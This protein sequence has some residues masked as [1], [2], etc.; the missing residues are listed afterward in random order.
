MDL[1][2]T[3][4]QELLRGNAADVLAREASGARARDRMEAGE[5]DADLW[6]RIAG[7]GWAGLPIAA[8][9]GGQGGSL[10]DLAVVIDQLC[11]HAAIVPFTTTALAALAVQR[12]GGEAL[13]GAL[14]PRIAGGGAS[15]S[16]ALAEG[17]GEAGGP[18]AATA[19]GGRV[20][21]EKRF[22]EY[23]RSSDYHL[24]AARRDGEP[25][26]ALV[27]REGGGVRIERDLAS[28]GRTPQAIVAYGDAPAEGWIGGAEAVDGL[29][30]LGAALAA[31]ESWSH[32]QRALDM[33]VEYVQTRV[34]FGRPIGAFQAVQMRLADLATR[35]QASNF[36]V[37]ELLWNLD[38][39]HDD[40][41]QLAV[42]KAVTA[43]T[44]ARVTQDCHLLH[45]GIGFIT[46]YD[47]YLH[48]VRG[49]EAALRYGGAGE[50]LRAV[51][52]A[53]L[54]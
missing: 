26:L 3:D 14:L 2:P 39:G 5:P 7:L 1:Q 38:R 37:H 29:R 47:L 53:L 33:T 9:H 52:G 22:V 6:A 13:R 30:R 10:L 45:G 31:L 36:L 16:I 17:R 44:V 24:V 32:A 46:E 4:L 34:Q 15:V 43:D 8:E 40:P 41:A 51:A 18:I 20:R 48:T 42:V 54:D 25:G 21:G 49:K 19:D 28:I 12:H 23:A 27:A 35:V 50:S 11:R